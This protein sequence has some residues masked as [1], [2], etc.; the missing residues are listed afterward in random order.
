MEEAGKSAEVVKLIEKEAQNEA[1][2][3][4]EKIIAKQKERDSPDNKEGG[5]AYLVD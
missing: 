5:D 4:E 1:R 2:R 3:E